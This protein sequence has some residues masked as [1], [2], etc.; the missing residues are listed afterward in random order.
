M[1]KYYKKCEILYLY[2]PLFNLI[3]LF[4]EVSPS[5]KINNNHFKS[6]SYKINKLKRLDSGIA[7]AALLVEKL[8][9]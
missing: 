1:S 2:L 5:I 9:M 3:T 6:K 8:Q 4:K 7:F